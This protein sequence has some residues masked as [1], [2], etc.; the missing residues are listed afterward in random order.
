MRRAILSGLFFAFAFSLA[1]PLA[2]SR[3]LASEEGIWAALESG[4]YAELIS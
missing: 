1:Q 4:G 2:F 3:S